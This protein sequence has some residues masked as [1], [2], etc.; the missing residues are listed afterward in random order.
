MS[1]AMNASN[2]NAPTQF[3]EAN[4]E[5]YAYRRFERGPGHP[6]LILQHFRGTLDN[7]DS[8]VTDPLAAGRAVR[9][10]AGLPELLDT[11]H[12]EVAAQ[13][14]VVGAK[15][16]L[17]ASARAFES[18]PTCTPGEEIDAIATSISASSI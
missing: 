4:D 16:H 11:T 12:R 14:R 6:L 18:S 13:V 7:W 9:E 5:T 2:I 3:V 15:E 8:A 10:R 1:A 17:R